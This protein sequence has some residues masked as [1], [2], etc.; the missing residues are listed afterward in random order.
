MVIGKVKITPADSILVVFLLALSAVWFILVFIGGRPGDVVEIHN[1]Q[2]VYEVLS[3][4][5]DTR[6]SVAGPLGESVLRIEGGEVFME[7]SPC[8]A[9]V[10]IH[11]GKIKS[12]GES[13]VCIPNRVY[14]VIRSETDEVDAVTY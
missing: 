11:T 6:I 14:V 13:I 1:E 9:K 12:A 8:P 7:S 10:C 3:L 2:G 4:D 5:A